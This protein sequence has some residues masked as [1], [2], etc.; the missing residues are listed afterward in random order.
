MIVPVEI[1]Y[2]ITLVCET[3]SEK[4]SAMEKI[5]TAMT[6]IGSTL[7]YMYIGTILMNW[8]EYCCI[9]CTKIFVLDTD[10]STYISMKASFIRITMI[11]DMS[12]MGH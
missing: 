8:C 6:N 11:F 9:F 10:I 7:K 5:C 1:V 3:E 4:V 12:S 2:Q